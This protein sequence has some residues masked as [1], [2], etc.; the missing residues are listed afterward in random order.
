CRGFAVGAGED[1]GSL[2]GVVADGPFA[3]VDEMV[4]VAA[5]GHAAVEVG[6]P[7]FTPGVAV[8]DLGHAVPAAGEG[9]TSA[10]PVLDG[11]P[12]RGGPCSG[13][14][15]DVEYLAGAAGADAHQAGVA[16]QPAG[17]LTGDVDAAVERDG[18]AG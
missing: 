6:V 15:A 4:V 7:V 3:F 1:G 17:G 14:A 18:A 10:P 8:V 2:G 5:D 11:P 12:S 9:A 16:G 13:L